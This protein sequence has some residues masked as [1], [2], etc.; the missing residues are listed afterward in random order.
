[1]TTE[2]PYRDVQETV[3]DA[4]NELESDESVLVPQREAEEIFHLPDSVQVF[5]ITASGKVSTFS[6]PST[7]RIFRFKKPEEEEGQKVATF[8][9]VGGWTHPLIP[10]ASPVLEAGNGAFMFPDVYG[11]DEGSSVGIVIVDGSPFNI[12]GAA[13]EQLAA[14]LQDL[15]AGAM[16]KEEA[17]TNDEKL[18]KI[19]K[20]IFKGAEFLGEAMEKGAEKTT[21]LIEYVSTA[22]KAK[23]QPAEQ[24]AKVSPALKTTVTGARYA[25]KAT[26]KVSGFV[27]NRVGKLSKG[28]SNYLA[29][30]IEPSLVTTGDGTKPKPSS[31]HNLLDAARGGLLGY[32]TVYTSLEQS[33]KVLGRSVK[34]QSVQVVQHKYG[35]EAG[36][37]YGEAM[38]S[39]GD[40]A[41]TYLNIQ[42]L[43]VKGL[44]KRTAKDTGK[45]LG[46]AALKMDK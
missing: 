23:I 35:N 36:H 8:I 32:G 5:F 19:G 20:A 4:L 37:V 39:A 2:N 38:T 12:D 3:R 28:L 21:H 33:A 6:E 45:Q 25:T 7:L 27:A 44:V 16:K 22:Q 13:Q 1:M 46:K 15:T 10:G 34:A 29:K 18:G 40:A 9:Q 43:G 11:Q 31:M 17:A 42:S 14:V 26:V 41:L 30:K 24:D